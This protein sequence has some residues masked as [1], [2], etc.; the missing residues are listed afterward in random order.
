MVPHK[1]Q[2]WICSLVSISILSSTYS[3][4]AQIAA[5]G[6]TS[7]GLANEFFVG[8]DFGRPLIS[9]N[10]I[11]GVSKPGVYHVPVDTDMVELIAYAGGTVE[12]AAVDEISIRRQIGRKVTVEK[13]NLQ[14][15]FR[16]GEELP[17]MLDGD[18]VQVPVN[19]SV[20]RT[21]VWVLILSGILSAGL[22]ATLIAQS[23]RA[24]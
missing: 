10:L 4:A 14:R 1:I 16:L 18:S 17:R 2:R 5:N 20:D 15:S 12:R 13:V 21:L 3:A 7:V 19:Q 23:G 22:S 6:V 9:V 11:S 24:R 8:K